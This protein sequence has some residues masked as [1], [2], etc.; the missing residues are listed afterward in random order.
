[1]LCEFSH[2]FPRRLAELLE[3]DRHLRRNFREET[4]TDLLMMGLLGL[5]SQ[6]ITVD[7]PDETVTGGDMEWIY[8]APHDVGG[9]TYVRLIIQAKRSKYASLKSGGYWFY[10]HLDHGDPAGSQAQDLIGYAA[11]SPDGQATLPLY[12]FYHPRSAITGPI[13]GRPDIEGLNV[14]L[15]DK[16]APVVA[17]GCSRAQ[18]R[19][20]AWRNQFFSLSD[21]LCWPL[22]PAAPPPTPPSP[23]ATEF[24][25]DGTFIGAVAAT[26]TWHPDFVADRLNALIDERA[27]EAAPPRR[28][29]PAGNLPDELQRAITGQTTDKDR[30]NLKRPRVIL[31]TGV[32]RDDPSYEPNRTALRNWRRG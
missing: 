30:A 18:K 28:V 22:S 21:L 8:A 16:V 29:D 5:S 17:G 25:V 26:P 2:E 10:D 13:P 12:F 7:F 20:G 9:G 32:T 27:S 6:D 24:L 3:R 14:V 1:M 4:A 11:T 23:G 31:T 19:L 15:A